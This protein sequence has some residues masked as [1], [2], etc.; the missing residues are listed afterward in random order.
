MANFCSV[1]GQAVAPDASFCSRCGHRLEDS[2]S[3]EPEQPAEQPAPAPELER[4]RSQ[5]P[6]SFAEFDSNRRNWFIGCGAVAG[7]FILLLILAAI[8]VPA[9]EETE[10]PTPAPA[11]QTETKLEQPAPT[12]QP[13]P[14][15]TPVPVCEGEDER[16]YITDFDNYMQMIGPRAGTLSKL[17]SD[18][19]RNPLL[20]MDPKWTED[21]GFAI[22]FIS[23]GADEIIGLKAP[24]SLTEIDQSAKAM[25]REL[26]A[27]MDLYVEG[28]DGFDAD[29]LVRG[30]ERMLKATEHMEDTY[31]AFDRLC[32]E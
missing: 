19:G 2:T 31:V 17:L 22:G 13:E 3:T 20:V 23:I 1:C 26:R 14:T 30:G 4:E 18:A 28:I 9:E 24:D 12:A 6:P 5:G 8:C 32:G 21:T 11:E 15:A 16:A 10:T 27:A 29:K 7:F 25:A